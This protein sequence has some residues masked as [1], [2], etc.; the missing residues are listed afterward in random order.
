MPDVGRGGPA[1]HWTRAGLGRRLPAHGPPLLQAARRSCA[2]RASEDRS[3]RGE[4]PHARTRQA[5]CIYAT[6]TDTPLIWFA[7]HWRYMSGR[8]N[9]WYVTGAPAVWHQ[10]QSSHA[11]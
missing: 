1:A 8:L 10:Y 3:A 5:A 7:R 6:V 9:G 11:Q 2:A 4:D